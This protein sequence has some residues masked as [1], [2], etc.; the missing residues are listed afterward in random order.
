[1]RGYRFVLAIQL[2]IALQCQ[3]EHDHTA[4]PNREFIEKEALRIA[5]TSPRSMA[6]DIGIYTTMARKFESDWETK[7]KEPKEEDREVL[8]RVWKTK[9]QP[10]YES[11]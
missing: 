7:Y 4:H 8:T 9:F 6:R 3:A 5:H 10:E 11:I 2:L 1:M